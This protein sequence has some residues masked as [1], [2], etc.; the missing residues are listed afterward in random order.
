MKRT[1][2]RSRV[3]FTSTILGACFSCLV[4][5]T[6]LAAEKLTPDQLAKIRVERDARR[7][8]NLD[9]ARKQGTIKWTNELREKGWGRFTMWQKEKFIGTFA[10]KGGKDAQEKTRQAANG[11][12]NWDPKIM[13]LID[14]PAPKISPWERRNGGGKSKP[15]KQNPMARREQQRAENLAAAR[16]SARSWSTAM[17]RQG[18]NRVPIISKERAKFTYRGGKENQRKLLNALRG[19]GAWDGSIMIMLR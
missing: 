8:K 13:A 3:I 4:S 5:V 2:A 16:K 10:F 7:A 12:V 15:A 19:I 14:E 11:V 17:E 1:T 9:I 18:W 6:S